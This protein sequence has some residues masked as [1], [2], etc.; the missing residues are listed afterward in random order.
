MN[1]MKM[2][3]QSSLWSTTD[4]GVDEPPPLSKELM[5]RHTELV[6]E[7]AKAVNRMGDGRRVSA[8][9]RDAEE[10]AHSNL[11]AFERIHGLTSSDPRIG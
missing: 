4:G 1:G 11:R 8:A 9:V 5:Q 6:R 2:T 7:Y 10:V 3:R